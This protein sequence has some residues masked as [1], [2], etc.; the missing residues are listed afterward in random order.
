MQEMPSLG[1][2]VLRESGVTVGIGVV[3]ELLEAGGDSEE[4]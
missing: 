4:E 2:F 1:R 3:V